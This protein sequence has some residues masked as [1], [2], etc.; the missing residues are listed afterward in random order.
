MRQSSRSSFVSFLFADLLTWSSW[1]KERSSLICIPYL[2]PLS[3]SI[4]VCKVATAGI[5]TNALTNYETETVSKHKSAKSCTRKNSS[6]P[7]T[8]HAAPPSGQSTDLKSCNVKTCSDSDLWSVSF[9]SWSLLWHLHPCVTIEYSQAVERGIS[10]QHSTF[11]TLPHS[12]TLSTLWFFSHIPPG[13]FFLV[14]VFYLSLSKK[15]SFSLHNQCS[16]FLIS[17]KSSVTLNTLN[18]DLCLHTS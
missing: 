17:G 5:L 6:P 18:D 15:T 9:L 1:L 13:A 4:Q 11:T 7:P 14:F 16:E 10:I 12:G 8:I 3:W 2:R